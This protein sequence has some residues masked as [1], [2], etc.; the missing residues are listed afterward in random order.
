M[1]TETTPAKPCPFCN[2]TDLD[3]NRWG[4]GGKYTLCRTCGAFGP[5][6]NSGVTWNDRN[7]QKNKGEG[8]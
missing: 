7:G 3:P 5:D 1:S 6:A 8:Q 4:M 2:G